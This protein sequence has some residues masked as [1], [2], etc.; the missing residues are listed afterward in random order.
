M[1]KTPHTTGSGKE[2]LLGRLLKTLLL[3]EQSQNHHQQLL[4]LSWFSHV[5]HAA[6]KPHNKFCVPEFCTRS[7]VRLAYMGRS[8]MLLLSVRREESRRNEAWWYCHTLYTRQISILIYKFFFFYLF[9]YILYIPF[10]N[11]QECKDLTGKRNPQSQQRM[12]AS[13]RAFMYKEGFSTEPIQKR[14]TKPTCSKLTRSLTRNPRLKTLLFRLYLPLLLSTSCI[15]LI[16]SIRSNSINNLFSWSLWKVGIIAV[17]LSINLTTNNAK[18][19]SLA[20]KYF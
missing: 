2:I 4:R 13:T 3:L 20:F 5:A 17:C 16:S 11:H 10:A 14:L 12:L 7:L 9:T 6:G 15:S 8:S 18:M 19:C 1:R